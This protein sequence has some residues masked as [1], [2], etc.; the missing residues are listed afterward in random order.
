MANDVLERSGKLEITGINADWDYKA[1]KPDS[2]PDNPRLTSIK[3]NP[4]AASDALLVKERDDTGPE[5]FYCSCADVND[6]RIEY[7]HGG[8][9]IPYIDFGDCTLSAGHKV[10]IKLWRDV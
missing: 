6:Q 3:F 5:A 8:R 7:Y 1:S 4:G 2:W 9:C 10:I